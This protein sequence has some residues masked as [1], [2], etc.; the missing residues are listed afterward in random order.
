MEEKKIWI[1]KLRIIATLAV[2]WLHTNGTI[3][4]NQD[5]FELTDGQIRFFAVNYYLMWWAVPVFFMLTGV[6]LLDKRKNVTVHDC[7]FKYSRRVLGALCLFGFFYSSMILA[8]EGE[9]SLLIIPKALWGVL[10]G[11][12]FSH[13]WYCY[14]LIGIYVILPVIKIF[15]DNAKEKILRYVLI[16]LFV[17]DF[18]IPFIGNIIG[19][20]INFYIPFSYSLLYILLGHYLV[21]ESKAVSIRVFE[22]MGGVTAS[23][24]A[25]VAFFSPIENNPY[26]GYSSPIIAILAMSIF[27]LFI[28]T[29]KSAFNSSKKC[30][31]LWEID[32]LCFGVYLIHPFFIQVFYRILGFT[33]IR[34]KIYQIGTIVVFVIVTFLS[35]ISTYIL[36]KISV[37]RKYIL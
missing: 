32:R 7:L 31:R 19:E 15:T 11:T 34:Y 9:R 30:E 10:T 28:L 37:L 26:L 1:S 22:V 36:R 3:W 13:L 17:F 16:V 27:E 21:T 25:V 4:G 20:R 6:L 12:T 14:E 24:V 29:Q 35:F 18:V 5:I 2:I 8:A 33:P 23:I